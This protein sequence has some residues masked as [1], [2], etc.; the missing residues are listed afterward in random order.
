[1][2][3]VVSSVVEDL[4]TLS[5]GMQYVAKSS[6]TRADKTGCGMSCTTDN[7]TDNTKLGAMLG[8]GTHYPGTSTPITMATNDLHN[9]KCGSKLNSYQGDKNMHHMP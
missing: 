1:M 8:Y 4:L 9:R 6:V 3:K 7:D 5:L 2:G